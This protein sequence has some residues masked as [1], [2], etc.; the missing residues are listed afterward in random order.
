MPSTLEP[1]DNIVRLFLERGHA[2]YDHNVSELQHALQ[3]ARFAETNGEPAHLVAATLVHDLGHLLQPSPHGMHLADPDHD[4]HHEEIG[5]QWLARHFPPALV[6]PVRLHVTAKRYLCTV[7]AA[8]AAT[9]S[10]SAK[11]RMLLQGGPLDVDEL[12]AFENEPCFEEAVRLRRYD[13]L[14]NVPMMQT[15]GL[16]YY[17]AA[18]EHALRA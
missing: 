14:G 15:P 6:D 16:S 9:L 18:L 12:T 5:A 10:D 17:R 13:D 1:V 2:T 4:G 8:Y 3:C 7:D 11:Q